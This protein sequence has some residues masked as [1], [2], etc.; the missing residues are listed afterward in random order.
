MYKATVP[1]LKTEGGRSDRNGGSRIPKFGM[2]KVF[3]EDHEPWRERILEP[4]SEI[5]LQWNRIFLFWG[6][7]ALFVDPLFF[8]LP[9]VINKDTRACMD[10][11]LNLGITVTC[12]RTFADAF[13]IL[14]I[15]IKFRTAYVSPTSRVF[16]KGELVTDPDMIAMRYLK[17]D[18]FIDL[19]AA[20]PLPQVLFQ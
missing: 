19:A 6:L 2:F 14:H 1:L 11:D 17:S 4:G 9:S 10:T 16:G 7:V 13:Y 8:Y 20:L 18:F 5:F 3:P 15:S 12:F